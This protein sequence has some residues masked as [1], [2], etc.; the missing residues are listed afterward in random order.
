MDH[1]KTMENPIETIG[2]MMA[3]LSLHRILTL[4]TSLKHP[5]IRPINIE[6]NQPYADAA[7]TFMEKYRSDFSKLPD[8]E[9]NEI[10]FNVITG[11][12]KE[13]TKT[14][15]GK[16]MLYLVTELEER[17]VDMGG[18]QLPHQEDFTLSDVRLRKCCNNTNFELIEK[19]LVQKPQQLK[20]SLAQKLNLRPLKFFLNNIGPNDIGI[21][22]A[23]LELKG[24]KQTLNPENWDILFSKFGFFIPEKY[25]ESSRSCDAGSLCSKMDEE[26]RKRE[27]EEV[28]EK[29]CFNLTGGGSFQHQRLLWKSLATQQG[30][31][32]RGRTRNHCFVQGFVG[33][34][35]L[36]SA[37]KLEHAKNT[38]GVNSFDYWYRPESILLL[39]RDYDVL[40]D[41]FDPATPRNPDFPPK[42][43]A[44][45]IKTASDNRGEGV[46]IIHN[47]KEAKQAKFSATDGGKI[48]NK[49]MGGRSAA[50]AQ[51]YLHNPL[52]IDGY[53]FHIRTYFV[54]SSVLPL[55]VWMYRDAYLAFAP[56][57]YAKVS[58]T[59]S[60]SSDLRRHLTNTNGDNKP[61]PMH[62]SRFLRLAERNNIDTEAMLQR[63]RNAFVKTILST[64]A[65][66]KCP[67]RFW[68]GVK[69]MQRGGNCFELF[70]VDFMHDSDFNVYILDVNNGPNLYSEDNLRLRVKTSV[71]RDTVNAFATRRSYHLDEDA[72]QKIPSFMIPSF[73]TCLR[74]FMD[75]TSTSLCDNVSQTD[76][77]CIMDD[78]VIEMEQMHME[79]TQ[80]DWGKYSDNAERNVLFYHNFERIFPQM[81]ESE[82]YNKFFLNDDLLRSHKRMREWL[83]FLRNKF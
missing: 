54:V 80:S 81:K 10:K 26:M 61:E 55:S 68:Q 63:M 5:I 44:W 47:I 83:L 12:H 78:E 69:K 52:L 33:G 36:I 22:S 19:G 31:Y 74:E 79:M 8:N 62:I 7:T 82:E 21:I 64:S 46:R 18:Q 48:K 43:S 42:N 39:P 15:K 57:R 4:S 3:P 32:F 27:E 73:M 28:N 1:Y 53:K 75:N 67:K 58:N 45:V 9:M 56:E 40:I 60:A 34:D 51:P 71:L 16:Q 11:M 24:M 25:K 29:L 35:K 41:T 49:V 59:K 38:W 70:G 6:K 72:E 37:L 2:N 23:A 66:S 13:V 65:L 76:K 77:N 17:R 50:I 14:V 20:Y 30:D